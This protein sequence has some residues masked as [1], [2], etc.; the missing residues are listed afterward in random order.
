MRPASRLRVTRRPVPEAMSRKATPRPA[1]DDAG[2]HYVGRTE[3]RRAEVGPERRAGSGGQQPYRRGHTQKRGAECPGQPET[4]DEVTGEPGDAYDLDGED[5]GAGELWGRAA[6]TDAASL[7][8]A[9]G[10]N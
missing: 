3:E 2:N 4:P 7:K 5:L 10:V 9:H 6:L 1:E 8:L